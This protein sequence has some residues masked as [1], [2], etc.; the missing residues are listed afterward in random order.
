MAL[1]SWCLSTWETMSK[2]GISGS[3]LRGAPTKRTGHILLAQPAELE[4]LP[5]HPHLLQVLE[6]MLGHAVW[7]VDQAVVVEDLDAADVL[8]IELGFVG[9]GADDVA[10]LHAVLVADFDAVGLEA[11]LALGRAGAFGD[12]VVFAF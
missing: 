10:G 9:D 4:L 1:L 7:Q 11:F 2:E 5:R 8:G 3:R 6:D 12:A